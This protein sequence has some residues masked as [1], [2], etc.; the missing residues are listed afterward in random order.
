MAADMPH[1]PDASLP[2]VNRSGTAGPPLP[3][4]RHRHDRSIMTVLAGLLAVAVVIPMLIL[5]IECVAGQARSRP[6]AT[7][8]IAPP[9]TVL[10]P[11]HDESTGI[12]TVIAAVRC[13]LR[14]VDALLVVADNCTD[15]TADLARAAG[16]PVCV[17]DDPER[18]GKAFALAHGRTVLRNAPKPVVIVLDADCTPEPGALHRLA[19]T[20]AHAQGAVQGAYLLTVP[21]DADPVVRISSF[22]FLVRNLV[23]QRGLQR[24]SAPALLQGTGMA[25][26]WRLFDTAPLVTTSLVEDLKL[27]LD[28]AL[29][30]HPVL[31]EERARFRS[32]ASGRAATTS[33][34][35]RWEQG[36][37]T[38]AARYLPRLIAAGLTRRPAL[39]LLAADLTVPPL[40]LLI[41]IVCLVIVF[42]T[43]SAMATGTAAPLVLLIGVVLSLGGVLAL[44]WMREGRAILPAAVLPALGRYILWKMPIYRGLLGRR[45]RA[46]VRTSRAP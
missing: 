36:M 1:D 35:T 25:L 45:Q 5:C 11:A 44:T 40:A 21:I 2:A 26:P 37:L 9:F 24:L 8:A 29:A 19:A 27:G 3:T 41:A 13:Q 23:R 16:A 30:G 38:T 31:F 43:V 12:A 15:A 39:L 42:L 6:H 14:A 46:W 22:A 18:I 17:R 34:R 28:L 7:P 32:P 4:S 10:I 33:Q 20:A